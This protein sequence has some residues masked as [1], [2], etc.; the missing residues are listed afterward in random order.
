[1]TWVVG[2]PTLF[3]CVGLADIHA[4]MDILRGYN[5][6]TARERFDPNGRL[7][8][9]VARPGGFGAMIGLHITTAAE[10]I[11]APGISSHFHICSV[12]RGVVRIW[13]NDRRVYPS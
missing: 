13:P 9:E 2:S 6:L 10:K 8:A 12:Q 1:M 7:R 11:H 5:N 4:Y 3:S